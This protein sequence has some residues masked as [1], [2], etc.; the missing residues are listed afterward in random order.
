MP[1]APRSGARAV[2]GRVDPAARLPC[3]ATRTG[4]DPEA[5]VLWASVHERPGVGPVRAAAWLAASASLRDAVAA[6]R[7]GRVEGVDPRA[8][9]ELRAAVDDAALRRA[10]QRVR[11]WRR[12]GVAVLGLGGPDYPEALTHLPD[13]PPLLFVRGRL[14]ATLTRRDGL[15]RAVAVVG[16]RGAE[17]WATAFARDLGRDLARAGV[18]V[19]SGLALGVDGAAH[20]GAVQAGADGAPTVAVLAGGLDRVHPPHHAGLADAIASDGALVSEHPPGVTP[21]RGSFPRRN[22][23]MVALSALLAVI[24]AP[25]RS[26]VQHSVTRAAQLGRDLWVV[27][28]RPESEFGRA[29]AAL[30]ADGAA[31]LT[32]ASELLEALGIAPD[33]RAPEE[34]RTALPD[35]PLERAIV[36][37]MRRDGPLREDD[38]VDLAP[39]LL[40]VLATLSRL[41]ARGWI[42]RDEAGRWR[43]A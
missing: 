1:R 43:V 4:P 30:L 21:T 14:P 37:R 35:D 25:F 9:H 13:P 29:A 12:S 34:A 10:D 27:P 32:R 2:V 39:T 11:R 7:R 3:M 23:I 28:D 31:P 24:Q 5:A 42:A 19:V 36:A 41:D 15:P 20:R 18:V 22:R 33:A 26:G 6:A 40:T 38:L 16:T 8:A 17:A